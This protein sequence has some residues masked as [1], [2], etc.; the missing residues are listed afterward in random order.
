MIWAATHR[1]GTVLENVASDKFGNLDLTDSRATEN[2]RACYPI[3]FIAN[4]SKSG[5]GGQPKHVVMLTCDAFGV[6]PPIAKLSTGQAMYHFLSGYT[7]EVAGTVKGL[8]NEPRATFSTCFGAPFLPRRPEVYGKMLT[9]LIGRY[10]SDCW[11][12]NTGW[13][14]GAYGEGQRMPIQHTRAFAECGAG[15]QP[16]AGQIRQGPDI[17]PDDADRGGGY[18]GRGSEP[19]PRLGRQI[20]L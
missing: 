14:G 18:S 8:G 11:L 2:T 1:F 17:R 5:R 12:V 10:G 19:A 9:E 7:A 6:L 13:S 15:W 4:A 16:G 20:R 3:E